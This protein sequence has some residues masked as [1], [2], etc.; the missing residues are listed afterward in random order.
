MEALLKNPDIW[1]DKADASLKEKL[2]RLED[3]ILE[4]AQEGKWGDEVLMS[5]LAE[6]YL[7]DIQVLVQAGSFVQ[8][9]H[10]AQPRSRAPQSTIYLLNSRETHFDVLVST[11]SNTSSFASSSPPKA[12]QSHKGTHS[13]GFC[14]FSS[15]LRAR[16]SKRAA[17]TERKHLV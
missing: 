16:R 4:K 6:A 3:Y 12:P 7:L 14:V 17:P 8:L 11:D 1:E 5:A 2:P 15:Y 10:G 13:L 9:V